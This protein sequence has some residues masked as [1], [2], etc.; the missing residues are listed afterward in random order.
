MTRQILIDV[1]LFET[2]VACIEDELLTD[3]ALYDAGYSSPIGEI[4]LGRVRAFADGLD[5]AFI[6]LGLNSDGFLLSSH[7][8]QGK[9]SDNNAAIR[10]KLHEGQKILVQ[11]IKGP[12]DNKGPQVS[13][14]I[15]FES[16]NL[17]FKPLRNGLSFSRQI[18]D[19]TFKDSV[20][21]AL[22]KEMEG[23]EGNATIR[24]HATDQSPSQ[25]CHEFRNFNQ[26]WKEITKLASDNAQPR[27]LRP[28][29]PPELQAAMKFGDRDTQLIINDVVRFASLSNSLNKMSSA[30]GQVQ[31][32]ANPTH[33]FD[34]FHVEAQLEEAQELRCPLPSG[35]NITIEQT[36]ALV[37]IDVN[38]GSLTASVGQSRVA[39]LTNQE[40]AQHIARQLRLRNLSGIIII[41]FIQDQDKGHVKA[42]TELLRSE[43]KTGPSTIRVIGMTE[44][45]LMQ[46]TRQRLDAPLMDQL[47]RPLKAPLAN[48]PAYKASALL[49][50]IS[51]YS[52][53]H[54]TASIPISLSPALSPLLKQRVRDIE[55]ALNI[56]I[57]W[58]EDASLPSF[59]YTLGS[60]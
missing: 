58:K 47:Q 53:D 14:F 24:S 18:K 9:A 2:R 36:E 19:E 32:W 46:L 35:G 40:A 8:P 56:H 28:S 12:K 52:R 25:L 31:L 41:D 20:S 55:K 38:S 33:L 43:T 21:I 51:R 10:D 48:I 13:A 17:V 37:V 1:G 42:L 49:R 3:M 29:D 27:C 54:K 11:I 59:H 57:S 60:L 15:Q 30:Y 4:Y 45:G 7:T 34:H 22:M 5:A 26:H 50:D 16:R 39:T 6:D 23:V 44:L